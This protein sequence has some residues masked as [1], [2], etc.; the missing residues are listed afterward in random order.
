MMPRTRRAV[1]LASK[2]DFVCDCISCESNF[3][4]FKKT[5]KQNLEVLSHCFLTLLDG[6]PATDATRLMRVTKS[7]LLTIEQAAI[8]YLRR[9]DHLHPSMENF[10]IQMLLIQIWYLLMRH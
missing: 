6:I 5:G 8:N 4:A 10:K 9:N 7:E 3:P 1:E 2:F